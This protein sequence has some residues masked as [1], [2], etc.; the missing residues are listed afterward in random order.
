MY[1]HKKMLNVYKSRLPKIADQIVELKQ[2][3][4]FIAS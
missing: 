3:Q 1:K 4:Q 2:R